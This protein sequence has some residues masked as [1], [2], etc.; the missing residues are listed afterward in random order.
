MIVIKILKDVFGVG[1]GHGIF[2]KE[3]HHTL[4]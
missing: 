1:K 4:N 2:S 3:I